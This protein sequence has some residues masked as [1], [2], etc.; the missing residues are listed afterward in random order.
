[1]YNLL[2]RIVWCKSNYH[3]MTCFV[4]LLFTQAQITHLICQQTCRIIINWISIFTFSYNLP[5][6]SDL[7]NY[8]PLSLFSHQWY[9]ITNWSRFI[10]S[11]LSY[12]IKIK[13]SKT[14][15]MQIYVIVTLSFPGVLEYNVMFLNRFSQKSNSIIISCSHRNRRCID[16]IFNI[17]LL[18]IID[19]VNK[20]WSLWTIMGP[21]FYGWINFVENRIWNNL[22]I[23]TSVA[24]ATNIFLTTTDAVIRRMDLLVNL[25]VCR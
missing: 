19:V 8:Q 12:H 23:N 24:W 10:S 13:F 6:D 7:L 5:D 11:A 21:I 14:G 25:F 2:P 16:Y 9:S 4:T 18:I 1:M 20:I 15:K 3:Y 17:R 22:L